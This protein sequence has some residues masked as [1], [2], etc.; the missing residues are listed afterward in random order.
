MNSRA[1]NSLSGLPPP[2]RVR[3]AASS[4]ASSAPEPSASKTANAARSEAGVGVGA[5]FGECGIGIW[6]AAKNRA[7]SRAN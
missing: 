6:R 5:L 4:A 7:L 1:S 3:M 2:G